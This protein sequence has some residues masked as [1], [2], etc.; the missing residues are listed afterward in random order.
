MNILQCNSNILLK[1]ITIIKMNFNLLLRPDYEMPGHGM[2]YLF[3]N[4]IFSH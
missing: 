1:Y 2:S 3:I 4:K